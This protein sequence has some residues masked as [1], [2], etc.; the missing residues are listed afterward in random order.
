[1]TLDHTFSVDES[2]E[3]QKEAMNFR[4]E[5]GEKFIGVKMGFTSKAKME[6]MGV[7]DMIWGILTDDMLYE[8]GA[9][10][11]LSKFIHPRAEPEICFLTKKDLPAELTLETASDYIESVA[12]AI[13]IID[14]RYQNFKFSLEDVIA[15]N[16]SSSGLVIGDWHPVDTPVNNLDIKM[17][18]AGSEVTSGNSNA[19]LGNPWESVIAA[20][21]LTAKYGRKVPAGSLIMAGA[22][23]AAI[24]LEK[25][26]KVEAVING[27]GKVNFTPR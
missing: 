8:N 4:F 6:Q 27:L 14:S 26:K 5:R 24:F 20:A 11:P 22:A 15:D 23:T 10:L 25:N 9:D 21:R 12:A 18:F 7:H 1:M 13:E 2:Y 16:C 3:I 17:T 19:I